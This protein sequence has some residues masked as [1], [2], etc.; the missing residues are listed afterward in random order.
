MEKMT[1]KWK[2]AEEPGTSSAKEDSEGEV[3]R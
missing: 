3:V 2:P 1:P